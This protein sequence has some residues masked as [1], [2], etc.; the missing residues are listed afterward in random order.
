MSAVEE[1]IIRV[2][3]ALPPEKQQAVVDFARFLLSQ[4]GDESWEGLLADPH[5]HP[6][7]EEFLRRS[8]EEEVYFRD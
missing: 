3:K 7:L 1:E 2:C 8:A 4:S 5:P 6:K